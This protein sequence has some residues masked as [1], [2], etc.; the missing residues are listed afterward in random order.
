MME[1]STQ[2]TGLPVSYIQ[3]S[4][5]GVALVSHQRAKVTCALFHDVK[6]GGPEFGKLIASEIL[7]AFIT[8]Y[9][10]QLPLESKINLEESFRDFNLKIAEVIRH[11]V[12]PVLDRL[13]QKRGILKCLL[14][15]G[16]SLQYS[17]DEVSKLGVLANHQALVAF[18]QEIMNVCVDEPTDIT[19]KS[20]ET[21]LTLL[22]FERASLVVLHQNGV[23]VGEDIASAADLLKKV[24]VMASNLQLQE[25]AAMDIR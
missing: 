14:T 9:A 11:S 3:L 21:T 1:F 5:V 10:H 13:R 18:S 8:T 4:T 6:D 25:S 2:R 12:R 19:L 15:V 24:L 22:R 16:D 23:N 17:T 7:N 20:A